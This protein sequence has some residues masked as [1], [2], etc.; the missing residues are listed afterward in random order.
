MNTKHFKLAG[1]LT[2]AGLLLCILTFALNGFQ[3]DFLIT[4]KNVI[5]K[6]YDSK[7]AITSIKV[8]TDHTQITIVPT[9]D[10]DIHIEYSDSDEEIYEINE[11]DGVLDMSLKNQKQW[12]EYI[13]IMEFQS[14]EDEE[15]TM[16]VPKK[17]DGD[18][19]LTT[20]YDN[21]DI[22]G[23][24]YANTIAL[25]TNNASMNASDL[26]SKGTILI[27]S[28]Y[29]PI[30]LKNISSKDSIEIENSHGDIDIK[31]LSSGN[32]L[33]ITSDYASIKLMDSQ[34]TSD[35]VI[36]NAHGSITLN[37]IIAKTI[38]NTSTSYASI[39]LNNVIVSDKA[40][41]T[42]NNSAITFDGFTSNELI[43][44]T[45]YDSIVLTKV[46]VKN[47]VFE[48]EHGGVSGDMTGSMNDYKI[49]TEYDNGSSNL[50]NKKDVGTRILSVSTSYD[51][52]N[53]T[54]TSDK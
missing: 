38:L 2:G 29:A 16:Y 36:D 14:F 11:I 35:M 52:I 19:D 43:S 3:I 27:E 32:K 15:I 20:S 6:A 30:T 45:S 54:F 8:D 28:S 7:T 26:S 44:E 17:Y 21:I 33:S 39:K 46:D 13:N 1:L 5:E 48:V 50:P 23:L 4:D 24:K 51:D 22:K 10:E 42:A 34:S 25:K 41:I 31:D 47:A 18:L 53:I 9:D 12:Y 40:E 37:K 49:T